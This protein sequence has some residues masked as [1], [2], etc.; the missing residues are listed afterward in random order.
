MDR[1]RGTLNAIFALCGHAGSM[2]RLISR[3]SAC[4][5]LAAIVVALPLRAQDAIGLVGGDRVDEGMVRIEGRLDGR[6]D[7]VDLAA[8][9]LSVNG[10]A[11]ELASDG[12]FAATVPRTAYYRLAIGGADV[13]AMVQTFGN[14]EVADAACACLR[15]PAIELVARKPGRIE[16]FFGGDSMAGRRFFEAGPGKKAVLDRVTIHRDLDRLLAPMAP[17]F[18]TSDLASINLESVVADEQP[19]PPAPKKYKFFSPVAL[20]LALK[21]A[22]I[23]HVSLGNNHTNDYGAPGMRTTLDALAG[24]Q[25]A[26]S[27]AGMNVTEAE[28]GSRFEVAGQKLSIYGFVGWRGTWDPN[29]T[30]EPDKAGAAWG[31]LDRVEAVTVRER[32]AGYL[33]IMQFH[34]NVEY[35]DRPTELSVPRFRT[36]VDK[37]AP[38]VIG[39]HPHVTQGLEIYRG[40]LIAHSLGNFL[41]D[42][43]HPHTHATYGLKVWLEN[44]R[45]LRAEAIPMQMLDYRPVPAVGGM[46]EAV[47]RRVH[48]L[49]AELGTKLA[50]SGGH[51]VLWAK[52]PRAEQPPC[53][54]PGG[55]GLAGIAPA[56]IDPSL[57]YGRN[58]VPRGDYANTLV[59][60]ARDRFWDTKNASV[61]FRGLEAGQGSMVLLPDAATR[62]AYL[63]TKS[64]LRDLYAL[65]FSLTS[66]IRT[67]RPV[68]VRLMIKDRPAE[69]AEPTPTVEG[70]LVGTRILPAGADWQA[71]R[72]DFDRPR[73]AAGAIPGVTGAVPSPFRFILAF[74]F[75]DTRGEGDRIVA[76]DDFALVEWAD[77]P[78]Q[79]DPAQAWRWTHARPAEQNGTLLA[80]T[81]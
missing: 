58:I 19:G 21:R 47:L 22:G 54:R 50:R 31:T 20:P 79:A 62:T 12:S 71:L 46:R 81:R 16:L 77:A 69:N 23:D 11:A 17:Y 76:F 73:I 44:G 41:F 18:A 80:A 52:G 56:C 66:R 78:S 48:W 67:A 34:G 38:V 53:R 40:A 65:R 29:Q 10:T 13:F 74:R 15:L 3:I 35:G 2:T 4:A 60:E 5:V 33:P 64:Y 57:D 8:V 7:S 28:A 25:L 63:Y 27:G 32:Q 24:A 61:D 42:Q 1:A 37:G 51:A 14:E 49:S 45:F 43:E 26:T 9:A 55:G 6:R 68:E 39:H 36:A 72:F 75:L 70:E 30:A 59:A